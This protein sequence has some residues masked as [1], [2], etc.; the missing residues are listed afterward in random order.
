MN[1]TS[2]VITAI[3]MVT[4]ITEKVNVADIPD[5]VRKADLVMFAAG[6]DHVVGM[7]EA[8]QLYVWGNT[9]LQQGNFTNEMKK[10]MKKQG[11]EWDRGTTCSL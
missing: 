9:R 8:G 10:A 11:P 3:D 1:A 6:D 5:E 4:R 2:Q 7:D